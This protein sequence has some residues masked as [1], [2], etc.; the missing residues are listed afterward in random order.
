MDPLRTNTITTLHLFIFGLTH[1]KLQLVAA[2]WFSRLYVWHTLSHSLLLSHTLYL[3]LI[4]IRWFISTRRFTQFVRSVQIFRQ[5]LFD[6]GRRPSVADQ[7]AQQLDL[8]FR[9][10]KPNLR[11]LANARTVSCSP[12]C[13]FVSGLTGP[14]TSGSLV[15]PPSFSFPP[16]LSYSL[17]LY[18]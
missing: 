18:S 4:H 10:S 7:T 15:L 6:C 12:V 5:G 14:R 9:I 1:I 17:N 8:D 3:S 16:P 2:T 11:G 13:S